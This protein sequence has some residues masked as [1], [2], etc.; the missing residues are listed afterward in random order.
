MLMGSSWIQAWSSGLRGVSKTHATTK[1]PRQTTNDSLDFLQST[2]SNP[3]VHVNKSEKYCF[4][5]TTICC[6]GALATACRTADQ[7][8]DLKNYMCP[9]QTLT[10][11]AARMQGTERVK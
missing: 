5:L 2:L 1:H 4:F 6:F 3:D 7:K 10:F 9:Y 8:H 11:G